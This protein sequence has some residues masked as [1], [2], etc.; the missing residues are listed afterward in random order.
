[1]RYHLKHLRQIPC[2]DELQMEIR[3]LDVARQE[4][5]WPRRRVWAIAV[6]LLLLVISYANGI[7]KWFLVGI[8][9]APLGFLLVLIPQIQQARRL[10]SIWAQI[11]WAIPKSK[12]VW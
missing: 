11:L 6:C 12:I 10:G 3:E 8:A 1:M 9:L 2:G 7:L 4:A 5:L